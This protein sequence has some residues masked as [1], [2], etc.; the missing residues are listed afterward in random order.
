MIF[1]PFLLNTQTETQALMYLRTTPKAY[2]RWIANKLPLHE[3]G[4]NWRKSI[5]RS[6][7]GIV[8]SNLLSWEDT[9]ICVEHFV[10]ICERRKRNKENQQQ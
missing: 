7:R 9:E 4:Q 5:I 1:C 3:L 10:L 2:G 6:C 8:K